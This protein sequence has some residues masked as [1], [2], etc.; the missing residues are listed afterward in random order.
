MSEYREAVPLLVANFNSVVFDFV[1]RQKVHAANLNWF[2][3]EQLPVVLPTD[4]G[5]TFG[6]KS[7]RD[8]VREEVS[9]LTYTA[10]DMAPFARDMG[11]VDVAGNV[12]P[13]FVFEAAD[14][15]RR[16]AKLDALYFML[17]FPSS[18]TAEIAALRD[19]ATYIYSTFPI[20]EREEI[21]AY[22][23]YLSRD[24]CLLTINALAAGDPD[25][26]I[27]V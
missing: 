14:R 16:R 27:V 11:L 25:A 4:Y 20:F 21:A 23:R 12:K 1:S 15:L 5:R 9:A 2:I 3:V 19:T 13:P 7:A 8:I 26:S 22:G 17:Y 10:H 6:P 18:T 24:L